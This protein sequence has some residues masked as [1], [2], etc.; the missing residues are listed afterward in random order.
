M[1]AWES[2]QITLDEIDA[3]IGEELSVKKLAEKAGLSEF[4]YSRLFARL[5]KKSPSEYIRLR[6]MALS[7]NA[8]LNTDARILDVAL[9]LGFTS[10]EH[11]TRTFKDT[12]GM[13]PDEYRKHPVALNRMTKPELLLNYVLVDEGVP[14]VTD[15]IVLEVRR[16][17]LESPVN[18][19]GKS[20]IMPMKALDG[21]G[22]E[23]GVDPL[24]ELW[25]EFHAN[26]AEI[27][28]SNV[29]A[30]E[31][32]VL[33]PADTPGD[34]KYFAG[35]VADADCS[36]EG[37][38]VWVLP[39]GEYVVCAFEAE[40]FQ[41]LVMDALYKATQYIYGMWLPKHSIKTDMF[42]AERYKSHDSLTTQMEIWL[43][44]VN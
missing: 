41:A 31:L 23:S 29:D 3:H 32:G 22:S 11:F 16:E 21:L 33:L 20:V 1:H 12:F 27:I 28:G 9:D 34:C 35:A 7:V 30:E 44:I 2:I 25:N 18:F 5:V 19:A 39:E 14:L 24:D 43:K 36:R 13:T 4:Y 10:H 8:L 40:N 38:D 42:S 26:K 17:K 6:R 37:S 15:G